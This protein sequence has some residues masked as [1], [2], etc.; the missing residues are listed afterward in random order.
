[1]ANAMG[2]AHARE[3][4]ALRHIRGKSNFLP[5]FHMPPTELNERAGANSLI[6]A[7]A[8]STSQLA[9]GGDDMCV[10]ANQID[11]RTKT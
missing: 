9:A 4:E 1:M 3:I 10:A 5:E 8:N 11:V 6:V 7:S 2:A